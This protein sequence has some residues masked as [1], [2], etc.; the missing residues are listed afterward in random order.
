MTKIIFCA[1]DFSPWKT[2]KQ[3]T[4]PV[5][6]RKIITLRVILFVSIYLSLSNV[7][8]G[9]TYSIVDPAQTTCYDTLF[10]ITCPSPGANYYGQ[11][12]AYIGT[13]PNYSISTDGKTV[14]DNNTSL[15]WMRSP[16][17]TNTPPV[18]ANRM[19]Y[20]TAQNWLTTV[21]AINYGGY[22]DWRI[23][24]IKEL[25]SL[26]SG[27]GTDPGGSTSSVGLT[28]FIDTNYFKFAYGNT[29]HG[30]RVIDQQYMS[31]N[32]FIKNPSESGYTK[33]F[34]V[35]FSDGRIKGYDT[36]DVLSGLPKTFYVQLV[37][38][39]LTYGYNTFV[40]N[41]D[42]TTTDNATGLMWSRTDNGSG[43]NW[44]NALAWVRTENA[45][46]YL[47]HSDWRMP[48]IKEL[49]SI[50]DYTH[51]PDYDSLPA[52]DTNYFQCSTIINEAGQ[53]DYPYYWS[54]TTHEG[55]FSG[56]SNGAEADYVPFGRALGWPSTQTHW[57]DVHGAGCQ[58]S[59]P[60]VGPPYG[61]AVVKTVVV[62][63]VTY[64]GYSHGPQGDAIRGSNYVRLVR[65]ASATSI[66]DQNRNGHS[67]NIYPNPVA[68]VCTISFGDEQKQVRIDILN[69]LGSKLIEINSTNTNTV[70]INV[71]DLPQG[72]FIM[73]I[74]VDNNFWGT[75]KVVKL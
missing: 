36:V 34:G 73:N 49:Q 60:K 14:H 69:M 28:P 5:V 62:S 66:N 3:L 30:E 53:L 18:K 40:N 1:E 32:I 57:V 55:Y 31:A 58:R 2:S 51:A 4:K 61:Y 59:D 37:R 45:A 17:T 44:E 43:L 12:A 10:L 20:A 9:Q 74:Y 64:T 6:M 42:Q 50:V 68:E 46:N 21:N 65:N 52:I 16:N 48:N 67:L 13:L 26:Y 23:P 19:T 38:G 47:G 22:N 33:D 72:I 24:T 63:G 56:S 27:K 25:Y 35:N 7:G 75:K 39:P 71:R 41:G 11:D 54:G 15:T 29:A 8:N 70:E